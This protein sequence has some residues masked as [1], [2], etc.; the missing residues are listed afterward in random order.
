MFTTKL[1][2]KNLLKDLIDYENKFNIM[3]KKLFTLTINLNEI[4]NNIDINNLGYFY[5]EN[6]YIYLDKNGLIEDENDSDLLFIRLDK[7]R[8]GTVDFNEFEDEFKPQI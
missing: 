1:F 2:L 5:E 8:D 6:L 4:F 7:N 3:R